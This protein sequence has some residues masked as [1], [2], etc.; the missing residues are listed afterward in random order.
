MSGRSPPERKSADCRDLRRL[1]L[2]D[3]GRN[4]LT[5]AGI[6]ELRATGVPLRVHDQHD[7]EDARW[8][9]VGDIE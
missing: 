1:E 6:A 2:L 7:E 8:F 4:S 5:E 3:L 9:A